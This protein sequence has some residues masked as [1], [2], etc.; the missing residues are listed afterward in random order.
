M[1]MNDTA[2]RVLD[3]PHDPRE[4]IH[5]TEQFLMEIDQSTRYLAGL[6]VGRR[7]RTVTKLYIE[8]ADS[9]LQPGSASVLSIVFSQLPTIDSTHVDIKALIEFLSDEETKRKRRR[10]FDWQNGIETAVEKGDLKLEHVPDRV[11][12]LLDDYTTWV[13][14]SGLSAKLG[15]GEFLLTLSEAIIE[16]LTVVGIPKAIK[17]LL[18]FGNRKLDLAKEELQ[19]PGR[20]LAYIAHCKRE[21]LV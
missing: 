1:R 15:A 4:H 3:L 13:K 2:L 18:E 20:E 16:G 21:F 10:L 7:K 14:G 11:A 6:A 19:A 9:V 8:S 12:T 5:A 17:T